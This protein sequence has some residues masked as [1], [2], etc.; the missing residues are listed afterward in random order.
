VKTDR[1]ERQRV[2]R[3]VIMAVR[4]HG[5]GVVEDATPGIRLSGV[6]VTLREGRLLLREHMQRLQLRVSSI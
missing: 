2:W 5:V 1:V 4:G 3:S 6:S